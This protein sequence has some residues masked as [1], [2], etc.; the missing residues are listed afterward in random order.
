MEFWFPVEEATEG[1]ARLLI[2]TLGRREGEPLDHARSRAA[3]FYNPLM[4]LNRDTA[5][6]AVS[7]QG[8][9]LGRPVEACEPMCGCGVRGVRLALEARVGNVLMGDLNPSG[10]QISE[11]NTHRNGVSD[12]VS[13]RLMDANL[14]LNLRSSPM[15]RFDYLDIDPFGSPSEFLDSGVRATRDGGVIALTATDMAPLCGVSPMACLRKY[16]GRP[17]RTV[18]THEVALRLVIGAAVRVAVIHE[19]GA[20]PLFGYY[21]DHYVRVYL[22]L[23]HSAKPADAALAEM[24][25]IAHCSRCLHREAVKGAYFK[26]SSLC[27]ICGNKLVIGGPMWLGDIA[28]SSFSEDMLGKAAKTGGLERRL[29]PLIETLRGEIGF[30]PTYFHLDELSSRAGKSSLS[31]DDVLEKLRTSGFKATRTHFDPRGVRT[32][33]SAADLANVIKG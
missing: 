24:G 32:T 11:E 9:R 28:D 23:K 3:V 22:G 15:N 5:V 26:M 12:K 16:G 2:P 19:M 20:R 31:R 1:A 33:A 4:R 29:I 13:I 18:Y 7:V 27:P 30:P 6:L 25:F 21:A 17:L 14:M 8:K 10:V